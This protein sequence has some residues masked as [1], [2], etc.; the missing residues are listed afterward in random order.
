MLE[1]ITIRD[2]GYGITVLV[3]ASFHVKRVKTLHAPRRIET[4]TSPKPESTP[5]GRAIDSHDRHR[6]LTPNLVSRETYT[7][8]RVQKR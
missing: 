2:C 8:K 6:A 7:C 4:N 3:P 1:M 5:A